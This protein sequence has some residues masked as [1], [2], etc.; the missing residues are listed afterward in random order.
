MGQNLGANKPERILETYTKAIRSRCNNF[1]NRSNFL[2][3]SAELSMRLFTDDTD[4]IFYGSMYLKIWAF[5]FPA[6]PLFF[7]PNATFQGLKKAIIV[8]Y[9]AIL[10]FVLT[11]IILVT[12][13][14][15][16]IKEDYIYMFIGLT[17][18]HWIIGILYYRYS[19]NKIKSLIKI[20]S[21]P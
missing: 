6:F 5:G 4:V 16:F 1:N 8:M 10:R 17:T 7:I 20:S 18:M 12:I 15:N 19:L 14:N 13:I 11:P 9:M 21:Y 3:F 2:F